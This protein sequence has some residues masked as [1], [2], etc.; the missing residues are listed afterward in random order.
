MITF[1]EA[2]WFEILLSVLTLV[3]GAALGPAI[4]R[5]V[6]GDRSYG[7]EAAQ[8]GLTVQRAI[9]QSS[10]FYHDSSVYFDSPV[11]IVPTSA[12]GGWRTASEEDVRERAGWVG[13]YIALAFGAA[14]VYLKYRIVILV[15]L[16]MVMTF[17]TAAFVSSL[18]YLAR[19]GT[20]VGRSWSLIL[21]W[22]IFLYS[23]AGLDIYLL[24]N[25]VFD[26]GNYQA[27]IQ[28][29][30]GGGMSEVLAQY[31]LTGVFFVAFQVFGVVAFCLMAYLLLTSL[32]FLWSSVNLAAGARGSRLWTLLRRVLRTSPSS[33][34]VV[35]TLLAFLAVLLCS[36]VVGSWISR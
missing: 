1:L 36:G 4:E 34:G 24:L 30:E 16:A 17:G 33:T 22:A 6:L 19:R 18:L 15:L 10:Y 13:V 14:F 3:L 31:E 12:P 21:V 11:I 9:H 25:P 32:V 20:I 23:T 27:L 5:L 35:A 2:H 28:A 29:F 8:G 26:S 7:V